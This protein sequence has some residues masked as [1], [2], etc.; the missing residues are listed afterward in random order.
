MFNISDKQKIIQY[1][2]K[3]YLWQLADK[4]NINF[5]LSDFNYPIYL[6]SFN[7]MYN[8]I[9]ED[10]D[11]ADS[12]EKIYLID[13]TYQSIQEDINSISLYNII[14]NE[15]ADL[16]LNVSN[17]T[18]NIK[19]YYFSKHKQEWFCLE[20]EKTA[21]HLYLVSGSHKNLN[22]ETLQNIKDYTQILKS[23][24]SF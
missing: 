17:I 3:V 7:E 23:S 5:H 12:P 19:N 18:E 4:N 24:V 9:T 8:L 21:T 15:K 20:K 16:T 6:L 14:K 1:F 22:I 10:N 2:N 11:L 13:E